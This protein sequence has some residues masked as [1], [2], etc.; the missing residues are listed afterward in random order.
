[1]ELDELR[2]HIILNNCEWKNILTTNCYAYALGLDIPQEKIGNCAYELGNI[3]YLFHNI[4]RHFM[5]HD[6][7]LKRILK[8]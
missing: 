6:E 3:Y 8:L 4:K 5:H 1:M 2:R 7:L